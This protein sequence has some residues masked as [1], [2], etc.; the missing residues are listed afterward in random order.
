MSRE[1]AY[2]ITIDGGGNFRTLST[3]EDEVRSHVKTLVGTNPGER[4]MSSTYG[5][6]TLQHVFN[7][8]TQGQADEFSLEIREALN[9]WVP[10]ITVISVDVQ[11]ATYGGTA[12]VNIR[13]ALNNNT[14]S[15]VTITASAPSTL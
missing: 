3:T 10:E 7:M 8:G 14:E 9:T 5:T 1:L 6:R 11:P 13:Y 12:L 4:V 2:P 15:S